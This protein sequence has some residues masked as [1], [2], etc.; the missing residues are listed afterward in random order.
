MD[1]GMG[2]ELIEEKYRLVAGRIYHYIDS[3]IAG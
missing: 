1:I 3:T 2:V